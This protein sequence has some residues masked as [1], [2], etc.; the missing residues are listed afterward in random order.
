[1][2]SV[3]CLGQQQVAFCPNHQSLITN[4]SVPDHLKDTCHGIASR[5]TSKMNR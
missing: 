5:S 1:V 2:I 4:H 3:G